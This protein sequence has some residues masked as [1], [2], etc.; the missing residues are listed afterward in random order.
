MNSEETSGTCVIEVNSL[1]PFGFRKPVFTADCQNAHNPL[2]LRAFG[3]RPMDQTTDTSAAQNAALKI[4][5]WRPWFWQA[6][7][8][9]LLAGY[10]YSPVAAF[11][12]RD[13][14]NDPDASHGF[15]VIPFSLFVVWHSR[16]RWMSLEPSPSWL[17]LPVIA[18]ALTLL[19][20]GVL[21]VEFFL[22]RSS[23]VFLIAGLILY[24][25]GWAHFRA[26][27]FPWVF[28]FLMIPIPAIIFNH[29]AFPL[30]LLASRFATATLAL[31]GVPVLRE[32]N[33]IQLASTT[34]EVA[35]ACS[36][37]R[38]LLSLVTLAVI[39]GYFLETRAGRRALFAVSAVP[40]AVVANALRIVG[41]GLVAN[42]WNPEKAEGFFHTFS[43]WV[44]FVLAMAMLFS[45]DYA[46]RWVEKW[47][48]RKGEAEP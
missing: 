47:R 6:G 11:L 32:G 44:I 48:G 5:K 2:S 33:V 1:F 13:W 18:G 15:L 39:Y 27:L 26:L 37:I 34:L 4:S 28:L 30:Q 16:Q 46:L 24:F 7:V 29:I 40:I 3:G 41:T 10:L 21:G 38:S 45:L 22:S 36:G 8:I 17:G 12:L 9:A 42:F 31:L 14:W 19:V 25:L 43:G 35:E 20:V 23:L